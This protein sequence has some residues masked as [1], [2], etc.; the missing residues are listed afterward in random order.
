MTLLYIRSN[1]KLEKM[2]HRKMLILSYLHNSV[3]ISDYKNYRINSVVIN[4]KELIRHL[5]GVKNIM[6][7]VKRYQTYKYVIKCASQ[8]NITS[9]CFCR[10]VKQNRVWKL[11]EKYP[12]FT[13]IS[14]L[15]NVKVHVKKLASFLMNSHISKLDLSDVY[16]S[17]EQ[18]NIIC[19]AISKSDVNDLS[20]RIN[21]K[22][23]NDSLGNLLNI[24][25][26]CIIPEKSNPDSLEL[27]QIKSEKL[28]ELHI[29]GDIPLSTSIKW[30]GVISKLPNPPHSIGLYNVPDPD[31]ISRILSLNPN[32]MYFDTLCDRM[33]RY[34]RSKTNPKL[35][36]I[37]TL[38][39]NNFPI[40]WKQ[41]LIRNEKLHW[42]PMY[43]QLL[44]LTMIFI[45]ILPP[46]VICDIFDYLYLEHLPISS[47]L[48][49]VNHRE[50]IK[51][52]MNIRRI[53]SEYI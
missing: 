30:A 53:K 14:I 9:I 13:N 41:H 51:L 18:F 34:S 8:C 26:L 25:R 46:Y 52:I 36:R 40:N 12:V 44:D 7:N 6:I 35:N 15:N 29:I 2:Y 10:N 20:I 4:R 19:S 50:K 11:L 1:Q 38:E 42:K 45:N 47:N 48:T 16:F 39:C 49:D 28:S 24:S 5:S 37:Y 3:K 22:Y 43:Q 27:S 32:I 31:V 23:D 17:R 21:N 33:M